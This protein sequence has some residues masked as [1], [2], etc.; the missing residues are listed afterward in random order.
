MREHNHVTINEIQ[1]TVNGEMSLIVNTYHNH[2]RIY[3]E[4]KHIEDG[5]IVFRS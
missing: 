3:A 2:M 5:G 1:Y 4:H